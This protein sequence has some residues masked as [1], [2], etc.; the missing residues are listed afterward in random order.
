M[1]VKRRLARGH[2]TPTGQAIGVNPHQN[3]AARGGAAKAGLKKIHERH[4]NFAKFDVVD[5]HVD[6]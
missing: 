5:F 1:A 3:D 2:F 4:L 6:G